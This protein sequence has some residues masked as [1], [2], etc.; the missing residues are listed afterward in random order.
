MDRKLTLLDKL[1]RLTFLKKFVRRL[2]IKITSVPAIRKPLRSASQ[3]GKLS[4]RVWQWLPVSLTFQVHL[5]AGPQ[6][7]YSVVPGDGIGK[8][9]YWQGIGFIGGEFQAFYRMISRSCFFVDVGANT[10]IFSLI[11]CATNSAIRVIAFEPVPEIYG[12]L[13]TNVATNGFHGRCHPVQKAVSDVLGIARLF[14]PQGEIPTEASL[15]LQNKLARKGG[16][17]IDVESTTLD[18]VCAQET[19]DFIKID[20]E[21]AE[22]KVLQGA[23]QLLARCR[24]TILLEHHANCPP[25]AIESVLKPYGYFFYGITEDGTLVPVEHLRHGIREHYLCSCLALEA[26]Q[27]YEAAPPNLC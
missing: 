4:P 2:A 21:G 11:A 26:V 1:I 8:A 12:R 3:A 19:V 6:F 17:L 7:S 22:H 5:P 18:T 15:E 24:P 25:L 9:L 13:V 16:T 23:R 20:V 14:I 10:G 27:Y